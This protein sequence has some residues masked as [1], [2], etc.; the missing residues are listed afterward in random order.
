[1]YRIAYASDATL[2]I[3]HA[4]KRAQD[5]LRD[6]ANGSR[7]I[8]LRLRVRGL[9]RSLRALKKQKAQSLSPEPLKN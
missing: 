2:R 1:M 9:K 8:E 3:E 5:E 7:A 6:G 4:I